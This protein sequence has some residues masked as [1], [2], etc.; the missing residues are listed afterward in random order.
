MLNQQE[1]WKA[2][3]AK[4]RAFFNYVKYMKMKDKRNVFYILRSNNNIDVDTFMPAYGL[5]CGEFCVF[6]I[7]TEHQR[8][9]LMM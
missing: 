6:K 5:H 2:T 8:N 4:Q 3:K 7:L 1:L 9:K